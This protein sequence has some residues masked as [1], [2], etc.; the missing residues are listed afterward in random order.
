[1]PNENKITTQEVRKIARLA[2]LALTDDEL[3]QYTGQLNR[4]LEYMDQLGEL[5]TSDVEPMSH[6]LNLVN[7]AR[8]DVPGQTL[9]LETVLKNAPMEKDGHIAVPAV[10]GNQEAGKRTR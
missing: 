8:D 5:D 3:T 1:M 4:I 7:V 6:V 10:I 9:A 2:R